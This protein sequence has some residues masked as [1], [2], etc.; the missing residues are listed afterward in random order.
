MFLVYGQLG[1]TFL[2]PRRAVELEI[3]ATHMHCYKL[4]QVVN[5]QG[6][7]IRD[8]LCTRGNS[9][10]HCPARPKTVAKYSLPRCFI[11]FVNL[12]R[13][14]TVIHTGDQE[15]RHSNGLTPEVTKYIV[16][17]HD[18]CFSG[19]RQCP[20]GDGAS[21]CKVS[22]RT[23]GSRGC[24]SAASSENTTCGSSMFAGWYRV[25]VGTRVKDASTPR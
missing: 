21:A 10:S 23:I 14:P 25:R 19:R 22:G 13:L 1:Q 16:S 12:S 15:Y 2:A 3:S 7:G 17:K 18:R 5:D 6:I 4:E 9:S 11:A 8:K 20:P 24:T